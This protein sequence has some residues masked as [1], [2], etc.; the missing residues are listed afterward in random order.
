MNNI[1]LQRLLHGYQLIK[2]SD[3]KNPVDGITFNGDNYQDSEL[4][5]PFARE[6]AETFTLPKH[7]YDRIKGEKTHDGTPI[8]ATIP[9]NLMKQGMQ[10]LSQDIT[11]SMKFSIDLSNENDWLTEKEIETILPE[12][13]L[14]SPYPQT[15][16]QVKMPDFTICILCKDQNVQTK[17]TGED[18]LKFQMQIMEHENNRF[19]LDLNEYDIVFHGMDK[20]AIDGRTGDKDLGGYTYFITPT[21]FAE[22]TDTRGHETSYAKREQFSNESL[23]AWVHTLQSTWCTFMIYLNYPQ[24]AEQKRIKGRNSKSWF[25]IPMRKHTH[26]EYRNKPAFEHKELIIK[27]YDDTNVADA[28]STGRSVG[29]AFHSVRKHIR[30]LANGKKTWVKAHFRGSKEQGVVSKDYTLKT[31]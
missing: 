2:V 11:Q 26:S 5:T 28:N 23:N 31:G 1:T 4:K 22:I 13:P 17:D 7:V 14:F 9:P 18:L 19:S 15:Y 30:T 20:T 12:T 24:I 6:W 3:F 25:D 27:M 16:L 8:S 29:T 10:K 21:W